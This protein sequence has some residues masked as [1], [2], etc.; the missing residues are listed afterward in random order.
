TPSWYQYDTDD[1]RSVRSP[2]A[3]LTLPSALNV[4]P[5]CS[6]SKYNDFVNGTGSVRCHRYAVIRDPSP[7]PSAT[8]T[9]KYGPSSTCRPHARFTCPPAPV[10]STE[11]SSS[12]PT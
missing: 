6:I 10:P 1:I 9:P 2:N 4:H 7:V 8:G 11:A 5:L 12:P 3:D